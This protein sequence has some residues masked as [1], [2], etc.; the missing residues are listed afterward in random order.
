M[1][2]RMRKAWLF[3]ASTIVVGFV[4]GTASANHVQY[5]CLDNQLLRVRVY[6]VTQ[7]RWG[8]VQRSHYRRHIPL[9]SRLTCFGFSHGKGT[10]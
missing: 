5:R 6:L 7:G 3:L 8:L 9:E 1:I 2:Y 4:S 10:A